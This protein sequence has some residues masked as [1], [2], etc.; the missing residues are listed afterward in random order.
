[1]PTLFTFVSLPEFLVLAGPFNDVPYPLH[2]SFLSPSS[3]DPTD[4]HVLVGIG[5]ARE[6]GFG[7]IILYQSL[8]QLAWRG[9]CNSA[10]VGT[11]PGARFLCR[12]NRYQ[13]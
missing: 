7:Q 13:P 2:S 12:L 10:G 9:F 11:V 3:V 6:I 1:M 8:F 5:E 4:A